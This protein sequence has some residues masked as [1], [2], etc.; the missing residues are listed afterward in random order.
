M[1]EGVA[2]KPDGGF[3]FIELAALA[4]VWWAY[5]KRL[6][7]LSD[8]AVW[9]AAHEMVSRRCGAPARKSKT[10]GVKELEQLVGRV[11]ES[12]IR[13]SLRRLRAVQLLS[14]SEGEILFATGPDTLSVADDATLKEFV[15][16]IRNHRRRIPVPRRTVR[17]LA[18]GCGRVTTAVIFGH[19]MRCLYYRSGECHASGLCKSSWIAETFGVSLRA[20][21][22]ARKA[23]GEKGWLTL[24]NTPQWLMNR[25]GAKVSV[26]LHWNDPESPGPHISPPAETAPPPPEN[27]PRFAP[28]ESNREPLREYN[29]QKPASRGG[30]TGVQDAQA[31]ESSPPTLHD[32]VPADLLD[33]GRLM[34]LY[35]QACR[36]GLSNESEGD[37][38]NFIAL[39]EH[40][41]SVGRDP[42]R[43]FASLVRRRLVHFITQDDEERARRRVT[44]FLYGRADTEQ[45]RAGRQRRPRELSRDALFVRHLRAKLKQAGFDGDPFDALTRELPEW[46]PERQICNML[47]TDAERSSKK[48]R[49]HLEDRPFEVPAC[50]VDVGTSAPAEVM[51]EAEGVVYLLGDGQRHSIY[52]ALAQIDRATGNITGVVSRGNYHGVRGVEGLNV[53]DTLWLNARHVWRQLVP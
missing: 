8:V 31:K 28:P 23:L 35:E 20:V 11:G 43:L 17:L 40:A 4:S 51:Q 34:V 38:L 5:Q 52:V 47:S 10:Y 27:T 48:M 30:P 42:C 26:N 21:K 50:A 24:H 49:V 14:Y 33:T 2:R 18:A 32:V 45:G 41:R 7:T 22:G 53:G 13:A 9:F 36:A 1:T 12:R 39:G 16:G 46:T 3:R 19:L 29:N 6:I 44:E 15:S 37:R 25:W